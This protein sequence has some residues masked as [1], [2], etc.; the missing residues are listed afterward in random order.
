MM[1]TRVLVARM[2]DMRVSL[3]QEMQIA[4]CVVSSL[5]CAKLLNEWFQYVSPKT[6]MTSDELLDICEC[7]CGQLE[8]S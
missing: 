6:V 7:T 2:L 1:R 3:C 8:Q 5:M 4:S